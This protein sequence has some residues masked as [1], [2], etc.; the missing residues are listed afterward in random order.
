MIL[1]KMEK[2]HSLVLRLQFLEPK[3]WIAPTE[4][5]EKNQQKRKI[6]KENCQRLVL[7][8]FTLFVCKRYYLLIYS[9]LR[10]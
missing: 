1:E 6:G 9:A 3:L 5:T 7:H 8:C 2:Y 10:E 4:K